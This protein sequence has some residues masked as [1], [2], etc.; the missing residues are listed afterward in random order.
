MHASIIIIVII[1][2]MGWV[3]AGSQVRGGGDGGIVGPG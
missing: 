3:G 1:H 2:H